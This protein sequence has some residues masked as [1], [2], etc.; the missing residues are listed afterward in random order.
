MIDQAVQD[1]IGAAMKV[2][3]VKLET[4]LKYIFTEQFDKLE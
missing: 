2:V 4:S 3:S 1:A